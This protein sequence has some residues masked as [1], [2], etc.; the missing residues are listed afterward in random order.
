M[1]FW[2]DPIRAINDWL[3]GLLSGF[4]PEAWVTLIGTLLGVVV[5][6]SFGL[7]LV[8]FL[9]WVERKIAARFQDRIGPNRA[10]PYGLLQTFADMVKLQSLTQGA[11]LVGKNVTYY[12]QA[13]KA[14]ASGVVEGASVVNGGLVVQVNGER[15][16]LGDVSGVLAALPEETI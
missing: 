7:I 11:S 3:L 4:L 5:V 6:A 12:S 16:P 13:T 10:G 14:D 15:V 2:S 9:I 8:I 1:S